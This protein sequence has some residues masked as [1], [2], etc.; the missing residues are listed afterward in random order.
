MAWVT[1]LLISDH[2]QGLEIVTRIEEL[3]KFL[4]MRELSSRERTVNYLRSQGFVELERHGTSFNV[5]LYFLKLGRKIILLKLKF[6]ASINRRHTFPV[7]HPL[8]L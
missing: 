6:L 5:S 1:V 3:L 4:Q 8:L 2:C 7:P